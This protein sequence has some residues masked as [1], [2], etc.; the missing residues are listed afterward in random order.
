MRGLPR[1]N[2]C[3][4]CLLFYSFILASTCS[5]TTKVQSA[6]LF[7]KMPIIIKDYEWTES[8]TR[9]DLCLP[10]KGIK[11][12]NIDVMVTNLYIKVSNTRHALEKTL[13]HC[14]LL[15][16]LKYNILITSFK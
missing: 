10:Q 4:I 8:E 5:G 11:S 2:T 9:I 3:F 6:V 14:V 7:E 13:Y 16:Q 15:M 12:S 1:R